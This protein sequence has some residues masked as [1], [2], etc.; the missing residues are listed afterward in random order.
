MNCK[1]SDIGIDKSKKEKFFAMV[2][3][4]FIESAKNVDAPFNI[5]TFMRDIYDMILE[6]TKRQDIAA[7]YTGLVPTYLR[8]SLGISPADIVSRHASLFSP[9]VALESRMIDVNSVLLEIGVTIDPAKD[10]DPLVVEDQLKQDEKEQ[11]QNIKLLESNV[12]PV[13]SARPNSLFT[14]TGDT[15]KHAPDREFSYEW[16]RHH[17]EADRLSTAKTNGNYYISLF[18]APSIITPEITSEDGL[19]AGYVY[20]ITD[21]EGN[22]LYFDE[23]FLPSDKSSGRLVFWRMREQLDKVQTEEEISKTLNISIP[24]VKEMLAAQL[25]AIAKKKAYLRANPDG[26]IT[27]EIIGGSRGF[28]PYDDRYFNELAKAEDLSDYELSITSVQTEKGKKQIYEFVRGAGR[29]PIEFIMVPIANDQEFIDMATDILLGNVVADTADL[30]NQIYEAR[31]NFRHVY[32]GNIKGQ[33]THEQGKL[34]VKNADGSQ[35]VLD[36]WEILQANPDKLAEAR[37]LV[38]KTLKGVESRPNKYNLWQ[39]APEFLRVF[40]KT[41]SGYKM[42]DL[43][44]SA[45]EYRKWV[46]KH[47]LTHLQFDSEG[48]FREENGY[49]AFQ[50]TAEGL[51]KY[52]FFVEPEKVTQQE[53][54]IG[55]NQITVTAQEIY[56]QLGNKTE[57]GNVV[58][59]SVYQ[60]KGV[61]YAK[62]IGG[63]FSLRINDSDKHF[64]NPFSSVKSEIAKGLIATSSTKESVERYIDWV[65]NSNEPR[66]EWIR[67]QLRSGKLKDKP[68]VYYKELGQPSHAT[69]LD[70]LINQYDWSQPVKLTKASVSTGFQGYKGGFENTGK[71]TPQGD[72]K[73]KAMREVADGFIGEITKAN[74]SSL[75]S[76]NTLRDSQN[77]SFSKGTNSSIK[78]SQI[79]M[80]ARNS[81]YSG[82]ALL[83]STK[84]KIKEA[85]SNGAEFVVGDMPNVDSQFIEYL[86]EIGA[87]FTIYHTGNTPRIKVVQPTEAAPAKRE[88]K[89]FNETGINKDNLF[90]DPKN[91]LSLRKLDNVTPEQIS[92]AEEWWKNHPLSAYISLDNMTHVINTKNPRSIATYFQ[93]GITLYKGADSTEIYHEAFH[94]FLDLFFS[95]EELTNL[96]NAVRKQPGNFTDF[97]GNAVSFEAASDLQIEEYLAE[98]F[99]QFALRGGKPLETDKNTKKKSFFAKLWDILKILFN[100]QVED[101]LAGR[102]TSVMLND[103]YQHLYFGNLG[104]PSFAQANN[105]KGEMNKILPIREEDFEAGSIL[106]HSDAFLIIQSADALMSEGIDHWIK[107]NK[108]TSYTTQAIKKPQFRANL[109]SYVF[110]EFTRRYEAI[111]EELNKNTEPN[112]PKYTKLSRQMDILEFVLSNFGTNAL[113]DET[114]VTTEDIENAI[115]SGK[116]F[117]AYHIQKSKFL[118][119]ED[120]FMEDPENAIS[121]DKDGYGQKS[122]NEISMKE[123][124]ATEVLYTIRSLFKYQKNKDSKIEPVLNELGFPQLEDFTTS[125]NKLQKSLVGL[126]NPLDQYNKLMELSKKDASIKQLITKLGNPNETESKSLEGQTLWTNFSKVFGTKRI[127][128]IQVTIDIDKTTGRVTPKV[129]KAFIESSN[130]GLQWENDFASPLTPKLKSRYFRREDAA[131]GKGRP[132]GNVLIKENIREDFL[133][134]DESAER[135]NVKDPVGFLNAIGMSIDPNDRMLVAQVN[136]GGEFYNFVRELGNRL[137]YFINNKQAVTSLKKLVEDAY[138]VK[139]ESGAIIRVSS[140]ATAYKQFQDRVYTLSDKYGGAMVRN[141]AGEMQYEYSL[142]STISNQIDAINNSRTLET[143]YKDPFNPQMAHLD[144]ERNPFIRSLIIMRK[145]YGENLRGALEETTRAGDRKVKPSIELLNSS[146]ITTVINETFH[147]MGMASAEVDDLSYTLQNFLLLTKYGVSASTQHADKSTALLYKVNSRNGAQDMHYIPYGQFFDFDKTKPFAKRAGVRNAVENMMG[148]LESEMTRIHRLRNGDISGTVTVGDNYYKDT[149]NQFVVFQSILSE[150]VKNELL[151]KHL[152]ENSLKTIRE[153]AAL[154]QRISDDIS[155]YLSKQYND[156]MTFINR[157]QT[158]R[159]QVKVAIMPELRNMIRH[160]YPAVTISDTQENNDMID[161]AIFMA[162]VVNDWLQKYETTVLFYGD[163]A[164]YNMFKEEFHKRNAGIAATGNFPRTD[165]AIKGFLRNNQ[166]SYQQSSFYKFSGYPESKSDVSDKTWN[167]WVMQDPRANSLYKTQYQKA[168]IDYNTKRL[169]RA[170]GRPLTSEELQRIT[171]QAASIFKEYD[172][173]KEADAQAW[174]SFDAYRE[175]LI[176]LGE[177][178]VYHQEIYE[179]ILRGDDLGDKDVTYFFPVKKMQY[180]G[181]LQSKGL[182][183]MGYHKFSLMPLIPNVIKG[184]NLEKMH[185]KMVS[186]NVQY[187]TVHSGSKVNTITNNGKMDPFYSDVNKRILA[188]DNLEYQITKNVIFLDYFKDQLE[189]HNTYKGKLIFST[190]LRKLIEEGLMEH[191][192]PTDFK[193]EI[194]DA[195]TRKKAWLDASDDE[196]NESRNWTLL[197]EYEKNLSRL[198]AYKLKELRKEAGM[199]VSG[200]AELNEKLL[201]FIR[202]ELTAQDLAEHEIDFIKYDPKT[203]QLQYDLSYHPSAAKIEGLLVSIVYKRLV[204]QKVKGEALVQVSGSGFESFRVETFEGTNQLPFYRQELD[205]SGKVIRTAGM[206][207]K[208]SLQGSFRKLLKHP[209]VIKKARKENTSRLDALNAIIK[210]EKLIDDYGLRKMI[211]ISGVR[212]PV[213]GFNSMEFAEVLEFL[214]ANAGNIIVLPSEIVAKAGSDFDIDKMFMMF[215]TLYSNSKGVHLAEYVNNLEDKIN[216]DE[217][218]ERK[219]DLVVERNKLIDE[220]KASLEEAAASESKELKEYLKQKAADFRKKTKALLNDLEE[221]RVYDDVVMAERILEDLIEMQD[222][223]LDTLKGGD[224]KAIKQINLELEVIDRDLANSSAGALENALM[225]SIVSIMELPQNFVPLVTPNSTNILQPLSE[226]YARYA[227]DYNAYEDGITGMNKGKPQKVI[228]GTKI[229]EIAYNRYKLS[230]NNIG[231][232]SLG[233]GAVDNTYNSLFNRIG[234]YMSYN[235][236]TGSIKNPYSYTQKLFLRHNKM[237]D[238]DGNTVIDLSSLHDVDQKYR[239]AELISQAINGWVDVAKDAW[240]FN[241]QGNKEI[242]PTLLFLIQAGVPVEQAVAFV[243]QPLVLDY[244]RRQREIKSAFAP[245]FGMNTEDPNMYRV[246]A[247]GDILLMMRNKLLGEEENEAVPQDQRNDVTSSFHQ[248]RLIYTKYIPYFLGNETEESFSLDALK[249]RLEQYY[250]D[251]ESGYTEY[252]MKTFLHFLEAEQMANAVT[253]LKMASNVDTKKTASVYEASAK[254]DAIWAL[255]HDQRI[256]TEIVKELFENSPIASFKIQD[257]IIEFTSTFFRLRNHPEFIERVKD[258][259]KNEDLS[260]Y[261]GFFND[262]IAMA[263]QLI[264]DFTSYIFQNYINDDSR[265]NPMEPYRGMKIIKKELRSTVTP[266][267]TAGLLERGAYVKDGTLYVNLKKLE[268][269]YEKLTFNAQSAYDTH[270]V[271]PVDPSRFNS[272]KGYLKFVYEREILRSKLSLAD[273][274]RTADYEERFGELLT[275]SDLIDSITKKKDLKEKDYALIAYELYLRDTALIQKLNIDF[276]MKDPNGYAKQLLIIKRAYSELSEK[277]NILNSFIYKLNDEVKNIR[278]SEFGMDSDI[279]NVYHNELE[280]LADP[281]IIKVPDLAENERISNLFAMFPFFSFFQAGQDKSGSYAISK[282]VPTI[283]FANILH[284]SSKGAIEKLNLSEEEAEKYLE[285]FFMR[286]RT[287]YYNAQ[288]AAQKR[289]RDNNNDELEA[290]AEVVANNPYKR[291]LKKYYI[292]DDR[293]RALI[294]I[295]P[296]EYDSSIYMIRYPA[297]NQANIKPLYKRILKQSSE[298][299]NVVF[300]VDDYINRGVEFNNPWIEKKDKNGNIRLVYNDSILFNFTQEGTLSSKSYPKKAQGF[301]NITEPVNPNSVAGIITR[302]DGVV[303]MVSTDETPAYLTDDTYE[304]NIRNIDAGI[305]NALA[306]KASGKTLVLS[307]FGYGLSLIGRVFEENDAPENMLKKGSQRIIPAPRTYL[308]LSNQ[309]FLNFGY[310]NPYYSLVAEHIIKNIGTTADPLVQKTLDTYQ[311]IVKKQ[312]V[313][314]QELRE[315]L[316]NECSHLFK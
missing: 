192:V 122:G 289:S 231:K 61:E 251:S 129:G 274:M 78:N 112:T 245:A 262:R 200:K 218:K 102:S 77:T 272:F 107:E 297:A 191:G 310:V 190:Q 10:I 1:L 296:F 207:V 172:G 150:E 43:F 254:L 54:L 101:Q 50:A 156:F 174:I 22:P 171:D 178:S 214:P 169:K 147:N 115:K 111:A 27:E 236:E 144:P 189:V 143:L 249:T 72:G 4:R 259:I 266:V 88:P 293:R 91:K 60:K 294:R 235:V 252:D 305:K 128:L 136:P 226:Q 67:E 195:A 133:R 51:A 202:K 285:P 37:A 223:M 42:L 105:R 59:H 25:E 269:D 253:Q 302:R 47:A 265:F 244:V 185:N 52:E 97:E 256:P 157:N 55:D 90:T 241:I 109:Y 225:D 149:G 204:K 232:R 12:S 19:Y 233:I 268:T 260:V 139:D 237:V 311:E 166:G 135:W 213:Q 146:G 309:L 39:H 70:Y 31:R 32:F 11:E 104:E 98:D 250:N 206:K 291:R 121:K 170:Y 167:T 158:V 164:L 315:K 123:L 163:P 227:S 3:K 304:Q 224:Q 120:R 208:I 176:R 277:Y 246:K 248:K 162:Y 15:T 20:V 84:N 255:E 203:K 130:V 119:F 295:K 81:E 258:F 264:N 145:L 182:P 211:R 247:K 127:P 113:R 220:A 117:M 6:A 36:D 23:N 49:V 307:E 93:K 221:A 99:R 155:Q 301:L 316:Q 271:A 161:E 132:A 30:D 103:L 242:S 196:K 96:F 151:E 184:T 287:Q 284:G 18:N 138:D 141:A 153:D 76:Y 193:T 73:D 24:E 14:T 106:N 288:L 312:P 100:V 282:I 74:S 165:A 279:I 63:I 8:A 56:E 179:S 2:Y 87:K 201:Q 216:R 108:S 134:Y 124:A 276:I 286:F 187:A 62:S 95:Q 16:I 92:A 215:P 140:E 137:V 7:A 64:G 275:K 239:I 228:S 209:E 180:F 35:I 205:S 89:K 40:E 83:D 281:T 71:G 198:T 263:N 257:F 173:M 142:R 58:I 29:R 273:Y 21:G 126:Y 299:S 314:D 181:P 292:S 159:S 68:I 298:N 38:Q 46:Q 110:T 48:V 160:A 278:F 280:D 313:T 44:V 28:L 261:G 75:T 306:L 26:F 230:S 154:L 210:D 194:L 219:K 57:S 80:L 188:F 212:I 79:V 45:V 234:A 238:K 308:Y 118:E 131:I 217:L 177:W 66:A 114:Q 5:N 243:T 69:A 303:T 34:V 300:L 222:E 85:F 65:L 116:G 13:F 53:A 94:G 183:V 199:S 186:Q 148:Y 152:G 125:W 229:F 270:G 197:K 9:I 290:S 86:Q 283:L 240:I 168:Y 33:I 17:V 41:D 267:G 82:K 175:L